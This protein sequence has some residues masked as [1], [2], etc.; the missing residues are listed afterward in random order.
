MR[1]MK[2]AM[3][4]VLAGGCIGGLS[5]CGSRS[6]LDW[7][8]P[9]EVPI[10]EEPTTWLEPSDAPPECD[11]S[12]TG[13]FVLST[14]SVV[15]RIDP[16]SLSAEQVGRIECNARPASFAIGKAAIVWVDLMGQVYESTLAGSGCR[17]T[18]FDATLANGEQ[19]GTGIVTDLMGVEHFFI[20]P[21]VR[22]ALGGAGI[23]EVLDLRLPDFEL[24]GRKPLETRYGPRLELAGTGDARLFGLT[25]GAVTTSRAN[26]T[27][28]QLDPASGA[29]LES[30]PLPELGALGAFDFAF[31]F[32]RLYIFKSGGAGAEAWRYDPATKELKKLGELPF[33]VVGADATPCRA[34]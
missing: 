3:M 1:P 21:F 23:S 12:A 22:T 9:G 30:R 7:G 2:R 25:D 16:E 33:Q 28:L 29:T 19:F 8:D 31:W 11:A 18:S 27:L 5:A 13:L 24:L 10:V 6:G 20:A 32:D 14:Q 4:W 34:R 17:K 26:V 15:F